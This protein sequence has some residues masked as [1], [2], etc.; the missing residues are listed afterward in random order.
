MLY[1]TTI[2]ATVL[3]TLLVMLT[4]KV[5][6]LRRSEKISVGDGDNKE[7]LKAIR[8][9]GNLTEFAPV[10]LIL[11]ACAEYNGVPDI[12]L[13]LIALAFVVGRIIHPV[14]MRDGSSFALRVRGMQLT[15]VSILVLGAV[16]ILWLLWRFFT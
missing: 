5:V 4:L 13:A 9:Q 7:L 3:G 12:L 16:N 1:I 14:G 11:I 8:A 6:A 10:G 15:L 2:S